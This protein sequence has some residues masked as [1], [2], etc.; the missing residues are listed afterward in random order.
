MSLFLHPLWFKNLEEDE[1]EEEEKDKRGREREVKYSNLLHNLLHNLLDL[2]H[3]VLRVTAN[4]SIQQPLIL[5][6]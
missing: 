5:M 4:S 6:D 3:Y 2:Q 1:E